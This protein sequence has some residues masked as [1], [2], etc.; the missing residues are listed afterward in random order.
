MLKPCCAV[1][2]QDLTMRDFLSAGGKCPSPP[3]PRLR[4]LNDEGDDDGE[5]E[6]EDDADHD[7]DFSC[8]S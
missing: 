3:S 5:V 6:V 2:P 7:G 8:T 4:A 1:Q